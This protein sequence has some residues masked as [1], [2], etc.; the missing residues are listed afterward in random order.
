MISEPKSQSC[1]G[2]VLTAVQDE[3]T[4]REGALQGVGITPEI[5]P[6]S[7]VLQEELQRSLINCFP[8]HPLRIK[9][10][11]SLVEIPSQF[12]SL[13]VR[14]LSSIK[15]ELSKKN[16]QCIKHH[17]LGSKENNKK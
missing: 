14:K 15:Y 8:H 4:T 5:P 10:K 1:H 3:E 6:L 12:G 17:E 2:Q 9:C 16:H 7:L 13:G 11:Y